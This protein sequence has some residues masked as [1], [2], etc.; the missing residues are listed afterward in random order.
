MDEA[1][2]G[3]TEIEE[4]RLEWREMAEVAENLFDV[5]DRGPGSLRWAQ[6]AWQV[7]SAVGL[8]RYVLE[9]ER[10]V[11]ILRFVALF[12]LYSEFC[13][14]AFDEGIAGDWEYFAP[15]GLVGEYP[16]I[17]AFSLG[18]LAEQRGVL[19]DNDHRSRRCDALG[20]AI[21]ELA[22][23]EYRQ[24]LNVLQALWGKKELFATLYASR[25]IDPTRYLLGDDMR[26]QGSGAGQTV[27]VR[28]AWDWFDA[29]ANPAG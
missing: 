29:G 21:A 23:A 15:V 12:A 7:L 17:D 6:S 1:Q 3:A 11:C 18:Q 13:V 25:G 20:V 19:V 2:A 16:F 26:I 14:R 4:I 8:N 9:V 10:T 5:Q 28:C 27:D 22:K 24:V